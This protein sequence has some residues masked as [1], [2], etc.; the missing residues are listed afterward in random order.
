MSAKYLNRKSQVL[1]EVY[2]KEGDEQLEKSDLEGAIQKYSEVSV[3]L[4]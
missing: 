1:N 4:T 2:R 3:V